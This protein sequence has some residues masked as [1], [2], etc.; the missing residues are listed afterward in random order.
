MATGE[1][2]KTVRKSLDHAND[3]LLALNEQRTH[4]NFCDI[5]LEV[6]GQMIQAHRNVLAACS[7]YFDAMFGGNMAE[8]R[9]SQVK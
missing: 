2:T 6:E 9:S 1:N 5:V 4:G 3:V 8:S 7:S